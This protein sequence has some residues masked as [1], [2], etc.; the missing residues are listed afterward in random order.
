MMSE[1]VNQ[2]PDSVTVI[3]HLQVGN[4]LEPRLSGYYP[5]RRLDALAITAILY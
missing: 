3:I 2:R 1:V 4:G 5:T